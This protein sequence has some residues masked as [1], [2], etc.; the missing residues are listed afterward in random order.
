[1]S[2]TMVISPLRERVIIRVTHVK[3]RPNS[4]EL[5]EMILWLDMWFST[6]ALSPLYSLRQVPARGIGPHF[7]F[8][9]LGAEALGVTS[10]IGSI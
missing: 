9:Y 1:M 2:R 8:P 5:V 3:A 6:T 10:A 4:T 7:P